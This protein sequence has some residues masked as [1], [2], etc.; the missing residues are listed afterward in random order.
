MLAAAGE[1]NRE[2]DLSDD[3]ALDGYGVAMAAQVNL[4][5]AAELWKEEETQ[6]GILGIGSELGTT[7]I[8]ADTWRKHAIKLATL[9]GQWGFA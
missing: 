6:F 7:Y 8:A 1:I 5:R 4:T 2:L 9:K 3:Q